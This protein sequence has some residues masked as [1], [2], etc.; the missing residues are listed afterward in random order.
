MNS[1][2]FFESLSQHFKNEL[3]FVVYRKPNTN[4]LKA[5][6][7][8]DSELYLTKNFSENGFVFA[9][10]DDKEDAILMPSTKS[11]LISIKNVI[12]K[13]FVIPEKAGIS[14]KKNKEHHINL[15]Q[16]GIEAIDANQ[17]QK[18]VLSRQE[19]VTISEA[20]PISIFKRLLKTYVS[21]FVYCW[22]HPKVGLWLGATPETL[23]KVEGKRFYTMALAGT[24]TYKGTLDVNWNEKEKKEQQIVAD[25]VVENLKEIT[26]DLNVSELETIKAGS[27]LHLQTKITG[28]ISLKTLSSNEASTKLGNLKHLLRVLHPTPAVCGFPKVAAK[29]F[30]LDNENY[31]RE[32]YT[33][34]LGEIDTDNCELFVNLRCM[35]L[36]NNE[37]IVYVGGGI[38]KDSIPENE[39]EETFNKAEIIKRVL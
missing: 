19:P 9:P 15:V 26:N 33:G 20:N 34:F 22:Y 1:E 25:Y 29:Q 10:F 38:T 14:S 6:L 39:W 24:Q 31:N 27:L 7:Q 13:L 23:L 4:P 12:S 18:V 16:K 30:I 17:F 36:K 3:P 5:I 28:I 37:A 35:Q 11:K 2:D 32:F 21:A 8:H